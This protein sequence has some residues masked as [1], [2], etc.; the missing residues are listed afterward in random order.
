MY[1]RREACLL[2]NIVEHRFRTLARRDQL[3]VSPVAPAPKLNDSEDSI[4]GASKFR[5][6]N[7]FTAEEVLLIAF[8]ERLMCMLGY[9][10]GLPPI[11]AQKITWNNGSEILRVF[12][13]RPASD[14][15]A[16]YVGGT[17][18][19]WN[20]AGTLSEV[21]AAVED[22]RKRNPGHEVALRL[23]IVNVSEVLREVE[24]R[25]RLHKIDFPREGGADA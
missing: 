18:G 22:D 13:E 4:E 8:A 11:P 10:D 16:G 20:V 19:G 12:A 3:P 24:A 5:G 25:A 2:T 17:D 21:A 14:I 6:W 15:W 1:T 9:A 7:R 23:F